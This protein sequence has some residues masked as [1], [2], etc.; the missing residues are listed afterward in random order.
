MNSD[1]LGY[2][3]IDFG[4]GRKLERFGPITLD[5][6]AR[7]AWTP[8]SLPEAWESAELI[9]SGERMNASAGRW[10][11]TS[12]ASRS[13]EDLLEGWHCTYRDLKLKIVPQK[14]GQLGA[15]P[16]HWN[17]WDWFAESITQGLAR[18]PVRVLHLFAYTGS[19]TLWMALQGATITHVDAM[20]QA[21]DW[22][23]VNAN[24]SGLDSKP[25]R[26]IV[27]DAR[28]YVARELK[29]GSAYELVVLDPPSYGHGRKGEAWEIHRDLVSL[30]KD[31]WR[32]LSGNSIGVFLTSHSLNISAKELRMELQLDQQNDSNDV[33]TESET[34]SS[35]AIETVIFPSFLQDCSGRRLECGEGIRFQRTNE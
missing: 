2:E 24:L 11:V 4:D 33:Q 26:W 32:L 3:L 1:R 10:T 18:G 31:C 28:K 25:I 23:R 14:T 17:H 19:T 9:Y 20:K 27:E 7:G 35:H 13:L 8:K 15:F 22:A 29:R 21:V 16:E 12:Q 6:P 5:R 34:G 30:M